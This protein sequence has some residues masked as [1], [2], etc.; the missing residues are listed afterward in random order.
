MGR[1]TKKNP[2]EPLCLIN[3]LKIKPCPG[4]CR[5]ASTHWLW[6]SCMYGM[7]VQGRIEEA[8]VESVVENKG[9]EDEVDNN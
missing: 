2:V 9:D 7:R 6:E 8:E 4:E 1:K 3:P 5:G